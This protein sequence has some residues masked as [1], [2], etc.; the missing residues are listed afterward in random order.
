MLADAIPADQQAHALARELIARHNA[1]V[2][3]SGG[4]I[5][6]ARQWPDE[7]RPYG[8]IGAALGVQDY[9]GATPLLLDR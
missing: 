1:R 3:S 5:D 7:L 4:V 6:A 2:A 9:G 8:Y